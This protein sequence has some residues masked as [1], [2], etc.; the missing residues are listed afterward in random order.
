MKED[1]IM[2][3]SIFPIFTILIFL[4]SC[5]KNPT[6]NKVV[7][8]DLIQNIIIETNLDTLSHFV[9]ILSGEIPVEINGFMYTI[10]SRHKNYPGNN[11]AA[12]FIYNKLQTYGLTVS[13]L[14]F[15]STGRNVYGKQTGT[16]YPDQHYIICAHYDSM[17]DSS[18][19]PGAD[20]NASGTAA[21][22]EAARVLQNYST[23]YS[24]IYALWDEE[25]QGLVGAAAYAERAHNNNE[26]I[27][28][29]INMDMIAW[30]SNDD[31]RFWVNVRDIA[32]SVSISD[33][34]IQIHNDYNI[35]LS[36]QLLNPGSGSDNL[37]FW[38]Y[39]FAA[40]GIEE[41]YGEDWN[42]N[43]HLTSDKI[44]NFN[45]NYFHKLSQ[46]VISTTASLA[47][48]SVK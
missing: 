26:N 28:G 31:G 15:S 18:L 34:L 30:D 19:S 11:I 16:E 39:G 36:P 44:E 37:V 47:E 4:L 21:V 32:N 10:A 24:I 6:E 20:D 42:A 13:N 40:L 22:L 38:Y 45:L 29:V 3:N 9:N 8:E 17:P 33:R 7:E 5:E 14:T 43:Y 25:E 27:I 35:G 23:K 41:M 48:V 12:N 46:L 1:R 2:K